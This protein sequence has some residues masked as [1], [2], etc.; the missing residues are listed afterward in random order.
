MTYTFETLLK[1]RN[2][3]LTI[4]WGKDIKKMNAQ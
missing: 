3:F 2:I 1:I 4:Y